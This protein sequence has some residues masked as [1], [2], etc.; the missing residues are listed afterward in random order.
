MQTM[1]SSIDKNRAFTQQFPSPMQKWTV[2]QNNSSGVRS[3]VHMGKKNP[4]RSWTKRFPSA[5]RTM[6]A[7]AGRTL[8]IQVWVRLAPG[9]C[10]TDRVLLWQAS[11]HLER[12]RLPCQGPTSLL[13]HRSLR[14]L[15]SWQGSILHKTLIQLCTLRPDQ[16]IRNT[17]NLQSLGSPSRQRS[18]RM[19]KS[20]QHQ[21]T[22]E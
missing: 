6:Q 21:T 12:R 5:P 19:L 4:R 7:P 22:T 16:R 2:L 9:I 8:L 10:A 1:S 13:F 18:M 20:K 15:E 17:E 11:L 14:T 3:A